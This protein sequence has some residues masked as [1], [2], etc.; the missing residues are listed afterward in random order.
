MFGNK[1]R[2][3]SKIGLLDIGVCIDDLQAIDR[4]MHEVALGQRLRVCFVVLDILR[5]SKGVFCGV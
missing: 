1:G 3:M 4:Q 2:T 5:D